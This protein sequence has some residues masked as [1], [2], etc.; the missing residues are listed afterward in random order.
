MR[1]FQVGDKV[2]FIHNSDGSRTEGFIFKDRGEG[3]FPLVVKPFDPISIGWDSD[4]FITYSSEGRWLHGDEIELILIEP[5]SKLQK[6]LDL[7]DEQGI[8]QVTFNAHTFDEEYQLSCDDKDYVTF[9]KKDIG[10]ILIP[11]KLLVCDYQTT[12]APIYNGW[13]MTINYHS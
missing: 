1:K 13:Y 2:S 4:S 10:V 6:I 5:T 12:E 8:D 7:L 9:H 3:A 11:D